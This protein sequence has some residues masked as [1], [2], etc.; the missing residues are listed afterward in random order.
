MQVIQSKS[1][2]FID[3]WITR[4]QLKKG[5]NITVG[6]GFIYNFLLGGANQVGQYTVWINDPMVPLH[7]TLHCS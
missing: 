5:V 4:A 3:D 7:H 2:M 1:R 6:M